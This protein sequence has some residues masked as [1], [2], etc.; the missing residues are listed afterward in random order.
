MTLLDW[1]DCTDADHAPY[2]YGV[3]PIVVSQ[4]TR[5]DPGFHYAM[6]LAHHVLCEVCGGIVSTETRAGKPIGSMSLTG[7]MHVIGKLPVGLNDEVW[8]IY[9]RVRLSGQKWTAEPC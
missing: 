2:W 9:K 3:A 5:N 4:D 6:F 7:A 8:K 1:P